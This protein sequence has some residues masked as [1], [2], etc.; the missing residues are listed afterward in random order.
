MLIFSINLNS[1]ERLA[2]PCPDGYDCDA[3]LRK[4]SVEA[5]ISRWSD[6]GEV[7]ERLNDELNLISETGLSAFFLVLWDAIKYAKTRGIIVGPGRGAIPS[8]LVS[9]CLGIT[10][11]DPIANNLLFERFLPSGRVE[12][13]EVWIDFEHA[14]QKE[15]YDYI[16]EKYQ[17]HSSALEVR[18]SFDENCFGLV[19]ELAFI[20]E[21]LK[22][23]SQK[24]GESVDLY[25]IDYA[26]KNVFDSISAG[27][28]DDMIFWRGDAKDY[29]SGLKPHSI[30]ELTAG[31]QLMPE[32]D[33]TWSRK[34]LYD[35]YVNGGEGYKD[36]DIDELRGVIKETK[37]VPIYQEQITEIFKKIGGFSPEMSE[38]ARRALAK[39][40]KT[41]TAE[42]RLWFLFGSKEEGIPGCINLGIPEETGEKIYTLMTDLTCYMGN[43]AHLLAL[44]ILVYQVAWLKTYFPS[45]YKEASQKV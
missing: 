25:Q 1:K 12:S 26:D 22:L 45:E 33:T 18:E 4:L 27:A 6:A 2:F 40:A 19:P 8:S 30:A 39:K 13:V 35:A 38:E 16:S 9:Y 11:V 31:L 14:R 28:I 34:I 24:N 36:A 7:K 44:A 43:K 23:V 3:Y 17:S 32:C 41:A 15:V 20:S 42:N 10:M 37:G 21:T 29:F 5:L